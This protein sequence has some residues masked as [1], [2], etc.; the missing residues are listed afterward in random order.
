MNV[1]GQRPDSTRNDTAFGFNLQI[2]ESRLVQNVD[3]LTGLRNSLIL[4]HGNLTPAGSIEFI[5]DNY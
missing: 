3:N 2:L 4:N 1:S 5:F